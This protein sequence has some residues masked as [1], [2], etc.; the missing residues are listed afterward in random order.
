MNDGHEFPRFNVVLVNF[1][2][3]R[4][5]IPH[6]VLQPWNVAIGS[7]NI[8]KHTAVN[9]TSLATLLYCVCRQLSPLPPLVGHSEASF[10]GRRRSKTATAS[11]AETS[12][13][14]IDDIGYRLTSDKKFPSNDPQVV[15]VIKE[16]HI[17][18]QEVLSRLRSQL[19]GSRE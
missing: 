14:S 9:L 13:T 15:Q 1:L 8:G 12:F 11:H 2:L 10:L 7:R 3:V 16:H 18:L 5:L 19:H 4:I 17:M 6:V